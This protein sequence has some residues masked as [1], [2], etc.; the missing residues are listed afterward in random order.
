[1]SE[2]RHFLAVMA[3]QEMPVCSLNDGIQALRIA[4]ALCQ[5]SEQ[6]KTVR[7]DHWPVS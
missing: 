7:L 3:G 1:M 5:A 6:K 2:T 4:L